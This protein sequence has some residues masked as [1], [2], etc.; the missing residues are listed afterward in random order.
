MHSELN[1]RRESAHANG[2]R[3]DTARQKKREKSQFPLQYLIKDARR[4][5]AKL[6]TFSERLFGNS[7]LIFLCLF[8]PMFTMY[9]QG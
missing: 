1:C 3:W 7:G 6:K 5:G 8:T 9:V 2:V 4:V